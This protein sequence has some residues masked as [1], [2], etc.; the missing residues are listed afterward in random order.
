MKSRRH[1]AIIG[2]GPSSIYLLKHL[3]DEKD[4]FKEHFEVISIFEKS[5]VMGIGMP[6][7]PETTERHNLS[8]ISS[9]E[10]PPL[11][12]SFADWLRLQPRE[13]LEG[14]GIN[15]DEISDSEVYSRLAL[16]GYLCDQ[17]RGILDRMTQSGMTIRKH[18]GCEV[19]DIQD[20]PEVGRVRVVTKSGVAHEADQVI[21]ATGHR[22]IGKD[23]PEQ[24]FYASPWPIFKLFP[25]ENAFHDFPVGILG[26]SL[27]AFDVVSSLAHRH[28]EF[29]KK[30]G[31]LSY[32]PHPD[33]EHFKVVL[34]S[35]NGT[36]PHLQFDQEEPFREIYRHTNRD[37]MLGLVDDDGY[38]RIGRYFDTVCR[39][40]LMEAFEKDE[41]PEVVKDLQRAEFG[42]K[43]FI[44]KMS[45]KHEYS[46]AFEGMRIEMVEAR[47]SVLQHRPIHW[48]EVIDDLMYTLNFH[49]ELLPAEDHL[50][51]QSQLMPFQMNVIA[52]MPLP[53]GDIILA[54]RDAGKIEMVSGKVSVPKKQEAKGK[55]SIE[56]ESEE[57]E[58][59]TAEYRLFIDSSGQKELGLED[60]PFPSLVEGG[61]VSLAVAEFADPQEADEIK[62]EKKELI[63]RD[64][65]R[66]GYQIGGLA[67]D[68]SY[69][70]I[71]EKGEPHPRLFDIA[72]PHVSGIRPYSYGLQACSDTSKILVRA[73][74]EACETGSDMGDLEETTEVYEKL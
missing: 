28:G 66:T 14:W 70:I 48:K 32:R 38:L 19:T 63:V 11:E 4:F 22:W 16:G 52:A 17:Y 39:P 30:S 6:Y 36:L 42:L 8:N 69:R 26:A 34:H 7:S 64:G 46:D 50:L 73:W 23:R 27:S 2:S 12:I 43:E 9:E 56:I 59:S 33:A 62:Q 65:N 47:E 37:E 51:L 61:L 60:Y 57:G 13:M 55:T 41:L 49:A 29:V 40:A 31:K 10:I 1:I 54:L 53:S 3:L 68:S 44:E 74:I 18:S 71:D 58:K 20:L 15:K 5:K 35:S 45:D 67:I 21:I 72:F 24:G 25:E